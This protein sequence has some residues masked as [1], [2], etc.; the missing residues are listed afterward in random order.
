MFNIVTEDKPI[1]IY[2]ELAL[3][4]RIIIGDFE[5][6]FTLPISFWSLDDY[7]KSWK[8]SLKEG[9]KNKNHAAL[10]VSMYDPSKTNF[11]FIWTLYF[12]KNMVH[13]QNSMFFL[14]EHPGFNEKNINQFI[15][16]REIYDDEGNKISEWDTEFTSVVKFYNSL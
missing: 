1:F 11:I 14:D 6:Y 3:P 2:E 16:P 10:A 15:E 8:N 7:K 13:I 9:I 4:G 5:E 12:E